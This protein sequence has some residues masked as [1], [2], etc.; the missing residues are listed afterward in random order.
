V[1]IR[2]ARGQQ[3]ARARTNSGRDSRFLRFQREMTYHQPL[4]CPLVRRWLARQPV[5]CQW[6]VLRKS[7]LPRQ[8]HLYQPSHHQDST[9]SPWRPSLLPRLQSLLLK[10]R[11]PRP[12]SALRQ[13]DLGPNL[14]QNLLLLVDR[15]VLRIFLTR[16]VRDRRNRKTTSTRRLSHSLPSAHLEWE[17]ADRS[18]CLRNAQ[19]AHWLR[20]SSGKAGSRQLPLRLL[21]RLLTILS[22]RLLVNQTH[23]HLPHPK[24]RL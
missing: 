10:L 7:F 12:C 18:E 6:L 19:N 13:R 24:S 20:T 11:L 5:F 15:R 2:T 14:L 21:L 23:Q 4:R 9:L 8:L 1:A 3:S 17:P 16:R 22:L